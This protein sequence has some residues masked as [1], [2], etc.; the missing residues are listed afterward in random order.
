MYAQVLYQMLH[1]IVIYCT[2]TYLELNGNKAPINIYIFIYLFR[3]F[4]LR[5]DKLLTSCVCVCVCL[6][7]KLTYN[8]GA[9]KMYRCIPIQ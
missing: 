3:S 8:Y 4:K 2:F 1:K 5:E 6:I 7:L 9:I